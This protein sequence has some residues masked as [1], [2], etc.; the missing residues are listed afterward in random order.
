MPTQG[1]WIDIS[2]PLNDGIAVYPGDPDV[3]ITRTTHFERVQDLM[4]SAISASVHAG[5]HVDAPLHFFRDGA[6]IDQMPHDVM[7]ATARVIAIEDPQSITAAELERH[8]IKAGEILLFK[9]RN[10]GLM[11]RKGF[12][13]GY[14]SLSTAAAHFLAER[15]VKAVGIDYLSIGGFERNEAEVHRTLLG[16]SIW[17]IEGLDLSAVDAGTYEFICLPL[18]IE[19]AEAAPARVLVRRRPG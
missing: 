17:I 10:A 15:R 13:P 8:A 9:T 3:R 12:S 14:V 2:V 16:A 19:G 4:L 18:L 6:T 1:A 5:T 11:R 7:V